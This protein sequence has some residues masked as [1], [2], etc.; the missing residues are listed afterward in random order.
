MGS[1]RAETAVDRLQQL[2]P[3]VEVTF[4]GGDVGAKPEEFFKDFDI[5][6]VTC[7]PRDV[8]V[9]VNNLCHKNGVKVWGYRSKVKHLADMLIWVR[10]LVRF[11]QI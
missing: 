2:N 9:H 1:N 4:D 3:M 10:I 8:L 5:V 6:L 11:Q 7:R